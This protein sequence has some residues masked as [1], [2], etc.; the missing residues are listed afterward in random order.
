MNTD[1]LETMDVPM[2]LYIF[3]E[4]PRRKSTSKLE[5]IKCY[6]EQEVESR[7]GKAH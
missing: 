5:E 1:I 7:G 6:D 2:V 3:V 4:R